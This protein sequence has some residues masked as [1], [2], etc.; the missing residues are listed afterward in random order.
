M[1]ATRATDPADIFLYHKTTRRAAYD[2][3]WH[4]ARGRGCFDLVYRNLRGEITEG[5]ITNVVAEIGG[6]WRTPPLRCGLLPGIWRAERLAAGSVEEAVIRCDELLQATRIVLGNSVRGGVEIDLLVDA[7]GQPVW[8][9][10]HG[11][12]GQ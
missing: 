11:L 1:L 3:D 2:A 6:R 10:R 4:Q 5:A 12:S 8:Q 9:R 7:Q